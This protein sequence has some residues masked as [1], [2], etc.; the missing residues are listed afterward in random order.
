M[1]CEIIVNQS[2]GPDGRRGIIRRGEHIL[3]YSDLL[4]I[5]GRRFIGVQVGRGASKNCL[6]AVGPNMKDVANS[7]VES[8]VIGSVCYR[9][10]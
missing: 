10:I 7:R 6:N 8:D 4:E 3:A 5:V 2:G 1:E 9:P